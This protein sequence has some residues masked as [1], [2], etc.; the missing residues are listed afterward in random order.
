MY[1]DMDDFDSQPLVDT[2]TVLSTFAVAAP[3]SQ[4]T[5]VSPI[6]PL[7]T[8]YGFDPA[9]VSAS[10]SLSFQYDFAVSDAGSTSF[11]NEMTRGVSFDDQRPN[12]I[13]FGYAL[14]KT[15]SL[16]DNDRDGAK[17]VCI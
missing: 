16:G 2:S 15:R 7:L 13:D 14:E 8:N 3:T 6:L 12:L 5:L 1:Q 9:S 10:E 11:I 4:A 17:E